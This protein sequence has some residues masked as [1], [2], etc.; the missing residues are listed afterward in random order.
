MYRR[1]PFVERA[2]LKEVR[3]FRSSVGDFSELFYVGNL[4][5]TR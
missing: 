5:M 1:V 4:A 3:A 2:I